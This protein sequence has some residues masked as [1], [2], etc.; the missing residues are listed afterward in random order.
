LQ[1]ILEQILYSPVWEDSVNGHVSGI[2]RFGILVLAVSASTKHWTLNT[3]GRDSSKVLRDY[4]VIGRHL[5]LVKFHAGRLKASRHQRTNIEVL[6]HSK[7][8][9]KI[10]H[11]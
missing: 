1:E 2:P 6:W 3:I 9:H 7:T 4:V 11:S 8:K 10:F 5:V